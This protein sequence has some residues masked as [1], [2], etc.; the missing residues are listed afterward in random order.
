LRP[1]NFSQNSQGLNPFPGNDAVE[2]Y[3]VTVIF[4]LHLFPCN[5][6]SCNN[7]LHDLK[8]NILHKD[9]FVLSFADMFGDTEHSGIYLKKVSRVQ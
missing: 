3:N 5:Y 2:K 4:S 9:M 6:L 7:S 8:S 1:A